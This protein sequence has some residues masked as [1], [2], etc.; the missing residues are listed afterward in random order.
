M[1]DCF[2][3]TVLS[4][5]AV[6]GFS[7]NLDIDFCLKA[8]IDTLVFVLFEWLV[9]SKQKITVAG[10]PARHE[11]TTIQLLVS[12]FLMLRGLITLE[13]TCRHECHSVCSTMKKMHLEL[14]NQKNKKS[15][16]YFL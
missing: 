3:I 4:A 16:C 12:K 5:G 9:C 7:L 15:G 11:F 10:V 2:S 6:L 13:D 14:E 8:V 1:A